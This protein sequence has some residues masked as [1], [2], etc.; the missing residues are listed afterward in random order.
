ML[1]RPSRVVTV[2]TPEEFDSAFANADRVIVEGDD[3]LLSYAATKAAK[4]TGN[5][6]QVELGQD[7]VA[8]AAPPRR[9]LMPILAAVFVLGLLGTP[10]MSS[11]CLLK[12]PRRRPITFIMKRNC[13]EAA[14]PPPARPGQ[15]ARRSG[16]RSCGR[17][18]RSS[19]FWRFS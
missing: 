15:R 3:A 13:P 16:R 17:R 18:S 10:S 4:G 9:R 8:V 12:P 7:T 1:F 2:T 6:V 14:L 5:D 11:C 19:P